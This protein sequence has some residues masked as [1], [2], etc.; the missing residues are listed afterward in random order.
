MQQYADLR[1]TE[2]RLLD[3]AIR[4]RR[5]IQ[6]MIAVMQKIVAVK[7]ATAAAAAAATPEPG[8]VITVLSAKAA[9]SATL[10]VA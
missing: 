5:L 6:K 7:S 9:V 3:A 8:G 2:E 1:N 10:A 4:Q